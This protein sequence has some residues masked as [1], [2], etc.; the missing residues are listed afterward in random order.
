MIKTKDLDVMVIATRHRPAIITDYL[1]DIPH[2][3][4]YNPDYNWEPGL[5]LNKDLLSMAWNPLNMYRAF[6][7]HVDVLSMS[8]KEYTLVLED[9]AAPNRSDWF[10][11]ALTCDEILNDAEVASLHG[12]EWSPRD[13]DY[14]NNPGPSDKIIPFKNEELVFTKPVPMANDPYNRTWCLGSCLA[15]VIKRE[16]RPKLINYKYDGLPID[17]IVPSRFDCYVLRKTCIEHDRRH[18]T[19]MT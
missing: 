10:E 6:R 14:I 2:H 18:G 16:S 1:K 4:H 17:F 12:R 13:P 15:Y 9:D 11:I 7:G 8:D 19:L 3:V 5:P